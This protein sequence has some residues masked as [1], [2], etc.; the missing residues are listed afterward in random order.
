M[1]AS[2]ALA[3]AGVT[4]SADGLGSR[5]ALTLQHRGAGENAFYLEIPYGFPV[6]EGIS[7]NSGRTALNPERGVAASIPA[8]PIR[9]RRIRMPERR[10]SRPASNRRSLRGLPA[11]GRHDSLGTLA[12][13]QIRAEHEAANR[14]GLGVGDLQHQ[15]RAG[16]KMPDLGGVDA[17]PVRA[18]AARQQEIDRGRR[19]PPAPRIPG[20]ARKGGIAKRL[21][22]MAALG[23]RTQVEQ[24]DDIGGFHCSQNRFLRSRISANTSA[25]GLP[26]SPTAAATAGSSARRN[27]LAAFPR[28]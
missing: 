21:A 20:Y 17:V 19:G 26:A 15:R 14:S 22:E 9:T 16:V 13:R 7:G 1:P 4:S 2:P 25:A 10:C 28:P 5:F 6:P 23:M 18:F 12:R 3:A 24:P 11:P 27:R 8:A